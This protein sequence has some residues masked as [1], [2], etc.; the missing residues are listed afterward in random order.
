[1]EVLVWWSPKNEESLAAFLMTM[2][3]QCF[4]SYVVSILNYE[5]GTFCIDIILMSIIGQ[6]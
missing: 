4:F 1:M 5:T 3:T 2:F 6:P